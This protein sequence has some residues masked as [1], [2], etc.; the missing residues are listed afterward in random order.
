[1]ETVD[2][3]DS[4]MQAIASRLMFDRPLVQNLKKL[5]SFAE[6]VQDE[7]ISAGLGPMIVTADFLESARVMFNYITSDEMMAKETESVFGRFY[8]RIFK[9]WRIDDANAP[10]VKRLT[11]LATL[12]FCSFSTWIRRDLNDIYSYYASEIIEQGEPDDASIAE[13][14]IAIALGIGELLKMVKGTKKYTKLKRTPIWDAMQQLVHAGEGAFAQFYAGELSR[15]PILPNRR[16]RRAMARR[17][18]L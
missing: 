3:T 12:Q 13:V 4:K 2:F 8:Q 15:H 9:E 16:T 7:G 10:E 18:E 14:E 11:F 5:P 6:S 1:M 17:G